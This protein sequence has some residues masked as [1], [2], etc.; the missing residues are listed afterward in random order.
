MIT[1]RLQESPIDSALHIAHFTDEVPADGSLV[2]AW[3]SHVTLVPPFKYDG[4]F[5][6]VVGL[7]EERTRAYGQLVLEVASLGN[8][9]STGS[10]R[11]VSF[12]RNDAWMQLRSELLESLGSL[13]AS[14]VDTTW[15]GYN[16]IPHCILKPGEELPNPLVV[17]SL[18]INRKQ[19]LS[20]G[21]SASKWTIETPL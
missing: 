1:P 4:S 20:Y 17:D 18:S 6:A 10:D 21:A 2:R 15:L 5:E 14:F 11:G 7:V 19:Q 9:G 13:G 12:I 8:F 3:G 16:Y